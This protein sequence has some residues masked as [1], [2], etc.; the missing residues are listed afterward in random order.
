MKIITPAGDAGNINSHN[1]IKQ[2]LF[3]ACLA[4]FSQR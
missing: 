4:V 2:R 1:F 3:C